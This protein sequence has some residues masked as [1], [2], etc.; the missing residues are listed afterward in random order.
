MISKL[1]WTRTI[2]G[3]LLLSGCASSV[4]SNVKV[5][6]ESLKGCAQKICN[7]KNDIQIAKKADNESRVNGLVISLNKVEKYC[8]DEG[9]IEDIK[10]KITD[11]EKDLK[12]DREGYE[13]ALRDAR[14]DKINKYK[15]KIAKELKELKHLK[16]ELKQME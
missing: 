12:E 5:N 14:S 13:E 15:M 10:E 6:C 2:L 16:A 7:L 1:N 4:E 3:L 9:L 11:T 8:T